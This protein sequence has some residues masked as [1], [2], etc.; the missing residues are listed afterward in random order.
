VPARIRF[1]DE[2]LRSFYDK[3]RERLFVTPPRVRVK[4]IIAPTA[5]LAE[6]ARRKAANGEDIDELIAEYFVPYFAEHRRQE[7]LDKQVDFEWVDQNE[8]WRGD[9]RTGPL[10]GLKV[11]GLSKP[12]PC[13]SVGSTVAVYCVRS[14][15]RGQVFAALVNRCC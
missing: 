11:G 4:A 3:H 9:K 5:K 6:D 13:P 10:W 1:S 2:D 12:H 14:M 7:Y 8:F 15:K